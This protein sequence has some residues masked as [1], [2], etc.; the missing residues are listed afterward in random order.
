MV[1]NIRKELYIL[2]TAQERLE[3]EWLE[4]KDDRRTRGFDLR[5]LERRSRDFVPNS[6][7]NA[8]G[9]VDPDPEDI[10]NLFSAKYKEIY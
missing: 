8:P 2:E 5:S 6:Y 4:I 7:V 3:R 1:F 9:P 10:P